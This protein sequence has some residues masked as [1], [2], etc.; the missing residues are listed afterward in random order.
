[1]QEYASS[2]PGFERTA[3]RRALARSRSSPF[4]DDYDA[5][6]VSEKEERL[7]RIDFFLDCQAE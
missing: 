3:R 1:G 2:A 4:S 7:R 5:K 6:E